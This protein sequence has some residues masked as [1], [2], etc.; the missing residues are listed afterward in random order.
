V[1][2]PALGVVLVAQAE[3][4]RS[5]DVYAQLDRMGAWRERLDPDPLRELAA[6]GDPVRVAAGVEN[7]LQPAALALRPELE[8]VID[9]V[10][11]AGPLGAIVSGSGPTV[12]G[13]FADRPA[14]EAAAAA[15][16]GA[17]VAALRRS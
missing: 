8:G 10:R 1:D 5:G 2:L 11:A 4:L 13:V 15:I 12:V 9:M 17:Q 7:D 6:S 3:G 16:P 14:A